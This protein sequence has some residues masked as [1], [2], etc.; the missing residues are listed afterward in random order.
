MSMWGVQV[1]QYLHSERSMWQYR[2][3]R[4]ARNQSG[5][6]QTPISFREIRLEQ[7]YCTYSRTWEAYRA[8]ALQL[9]L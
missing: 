7:L 4:R 8:E 9:R 5:T 1:P 3:D 6:R 2:V